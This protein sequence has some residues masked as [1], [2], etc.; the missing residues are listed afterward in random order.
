MLQTLA[1]LGLLEEQQLALLVPL[2]RQ[3]I[4]ALL[5]ILVPQVTQA[6]L[7][8]KVILEKLDRRVMWARLVLLVA[9]AQLQTL[10]RQ[11]QVA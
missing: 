2:A 11:G 6:T 5:A 9:L 3:Q 10:V 8:I 4:L 7:E 1:Q